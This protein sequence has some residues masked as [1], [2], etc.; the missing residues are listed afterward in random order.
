[1]LHAKYAKMKKKEDYLILLYVIDQIL[2][3]NRM[4]TLF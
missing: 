3:I 2:L 1:M 4:I